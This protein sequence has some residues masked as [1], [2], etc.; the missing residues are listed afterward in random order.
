V[1]GSH[2]V[3]DDEIDEIIIHEIIDKIEVPVYQILVGGL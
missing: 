2:R 1:G 3:V